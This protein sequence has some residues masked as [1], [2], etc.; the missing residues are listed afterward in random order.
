MPATLGL[1]HAQSR[2]NQAE[3]CRQA[4][5]MLDE[6]RT[7]GEGIDCW[8]IHIDQK[9]GTR[10]LAL[11]PDEVIPQ[12]ITEND[13]DILVMGTV[14]RSGIPGFVIGNTAEN[15]LQN[16]NCSLIAIKPNGFMTPIKAY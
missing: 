15:V 12:F 13:I 3:Y 14:G 1:E 10:A 9:I 8:I 16:L 6:N 11:S 4:E 2:T 5:T 7:L